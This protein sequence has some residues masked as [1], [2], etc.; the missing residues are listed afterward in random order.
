VLISNPIVAEENEKIAREE[1]QQ[2]QHL[3][4]I[5]ISHLVSPIQSMPFEFN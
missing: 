1:E 2:Q 5:F 4:S 3:S